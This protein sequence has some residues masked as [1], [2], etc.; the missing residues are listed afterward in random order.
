MKERG[1]KDLSSNTAQVLDHGRVVDVHNLDDFF[2]RLEDN[3][4][5]LYATASLAW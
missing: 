3:W 4:D 5:E 2:K 1:T